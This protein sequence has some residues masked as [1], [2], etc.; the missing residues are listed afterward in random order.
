MVTTVDGV[1]LAGDGN[2]RV[3]VPPPWRSFL[4]GRPK[5][6]WAE[7]A[8]DGREELETL[9][10]VGLR[11]GVGVGIKEGGRGE[12]ENAARGA[13]SMAVDGFSC[14]R[15]IHDCH[16]LSLSR[17]FPLLFDHSLPV[18]SPFPRF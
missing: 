17:L 18:S 3:T 15:T 12:G 6:V 7:E 2:G 10:G 13:S 5:V 9:L 14:G 11:I 1:G 4:P 8:Y 16:S